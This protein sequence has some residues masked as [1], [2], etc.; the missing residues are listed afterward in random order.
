MFFHRLR[1]KIGPSPPSASCW[2]YDVEMA[3]WSEKELKNLWRSKIKRTDIVDQKVRN[4]PNGGR[5]VRRDSCGGE[6]EGSRTGGLGPGWR[7]TGPGRNPGEADT[8]KGRRRK[9][10]LEQYKETPR[11]GSGIGSIDATKV[12]QKLTI[13]RC[14]FGGT[15]S[16]SSTVWSPRLEANCKSGEECQSK[17]R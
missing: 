4:W 14:R 12:M 3:I 17:V 13:W 16:W 9:M 10:K 7:P 15:R 2:I 11:G 6:R 1:A 5:G 8:E